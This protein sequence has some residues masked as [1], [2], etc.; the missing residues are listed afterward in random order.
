MAERFWDKF[1]FQRLQQNQMFMRLPHDVKGVFM[2]LRILAGNCDAADGTLPIGAAKRAKEE[3]VLDYLTYGDKAKR[4]FFKRALGRLVTA[5][6]LTV[7]AGGV[8]KIAGYEEEQGLGRTIDTNRKRAVAKEKFQENVNRAGAY[9][10]KVFERSEA[11]ALPY[12][13]LHASIRSRSGCIKRTADALLQAMVEGGVLVCVG[14]GGLYALASLGSPPGSGSGSAGDGAENVLRNFPLESESVPEPEK[15]GTNVPSVG[16]TGAR[17]RSPSASQPTC[18]PGLEGAP[19]RSEGGQDDFSVGAGTPL[20]PED[21]WDAKDPLQAA[22]AFLRT[23]PGWSETQVGDKPA[24][25]YA[26]RGRW[27]DLRKAV[28]PKKANELWRESLFDILS[29]HCD[30]QS[31]NSWTAGFLSKLKIKQEVFESLESAE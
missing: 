5:G 26:L 27:R 28:G 29:D 24:S 6:V 23:K 10:K 4:N 15:E 20:S 25:Q 30:K 16:P 21:A 18:A 3:D 7:T 9:L 12:D 19:E 2:E 17:G 1:G 11:R 31:W 22:E 8:I 14:E 13:M